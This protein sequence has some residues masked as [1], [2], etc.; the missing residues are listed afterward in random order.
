MPARQRVPLRITHG[1]GLLPRGRYFCRV[2]VRIG[3]RK[4]PNVARA[5]PKPGRHETSSTRALR[6]LPT[7]FYPMVTAI[8]ALP[9]TC[10]ISS[11]RVR[12]ALVVAT[13]PIIAATIPMMIAFDPYMI[14]CRRRGNGLWWRW[15][16][17][18]RGSLHVDGL[19]R[20]LDVGGLRRT[21]GN[22]A[23]AHD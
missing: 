15:R 7:T 17:S 5:I 21:R 16:G 3:A 22:I 20:L 1:S 13:L 2:L 19:R 14:G 12:P 4:M 6:L 8:T 9:M 10:D 11:I 23:S 18:R